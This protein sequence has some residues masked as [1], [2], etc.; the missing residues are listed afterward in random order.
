M[1]RM[2]RVKDFNSIFHVMCRS[3]S[4]VDL[5]KTKDDK[6]RYIYYIKKYQKTYEFKVY[7]YCLMDTHLHLLIDANGADIS[8]IMHSINLSYAQYFNGFHKRHGHLFQDR[9]KS[10]IIANERYLFAV[11]AYIHNNP[12]DIT[13]FENHP[14]KYE[15]SSLSVYLGIRQDPYNLISSSFILSLFGK[16][17]E[18]ARQ[19]YIR[20]VC[21]SNQLKYNEEIEFKNETTEYRSERTILVRNYNINDVI[22]YIAD[23]M[24]IPKIKL[25]V[26]YCRKI[27]NAKALL[28]L[29]LRSLC[30][31]KCSDICKTLGNI[32]Q[33]RV[34]ELSSIGVKL[35]EENEK[36]RHI[37]ENFIKP[38]VGLSNLL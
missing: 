22:I 2:A 3:I 24:D 36:C 21:N 19:Q 20:F 28:V 26:K 31:H 23:C 1:P 13:G 8:R 4:E 16:N 29:L 9:F 6:L 11:S 17:P 18:V 37:V 27:I 30:N 15:F 7:G 14:E 33:S 34:S 35:I 38:P 5:F 32:T 25:H 10:K 12:M